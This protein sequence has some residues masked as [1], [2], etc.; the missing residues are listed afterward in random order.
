MAYVLP[1]LLGYLL[2]SISFAAV[3]G[4]LSRIDVSRQG[5]GNLGARNALRVLGPRWAAFVLAGDVGKGALA[6]VMG[7]ILAGDATGALAAILGAVL[8]H[9]FSLLLSG[10]GGKGLATLVGGYVV[11]S[12]AA[13][14]GG[15]GVAAASLVLLGNVYLA[16]AVAL[17]SVPAWTYL[18]MGGGP[19]VMVA[20]LI[21][22]ASLA[23]HWR[24]LAALRGR[25]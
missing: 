14:V 16:A 15:L 8:G 20:S 3:A 12:P 13:V 7:G 21:A 6:S 2:G 25:R 11:L 5:S 9:N 10:R 22:L 24:D 19:P 4:R 17:L 23:R 18:A 1:V